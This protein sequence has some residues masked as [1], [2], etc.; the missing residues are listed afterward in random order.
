MDDVIHLSDNCGA[1]GYFYSGSLLTSL[2]S[3][4]V[5]VFR[6]PLLFLSKGAS[7]EGMG[8]GGRSFPL[9]LWGFNHYTFLANFPPTPAL[10][11]HFAL[12]EK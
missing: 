6:S 7:L 11:Q 1:S 9:L 8:G 10:S 3:I 2:F 4:N 12:S 5:N